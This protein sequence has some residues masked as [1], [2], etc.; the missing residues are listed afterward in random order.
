MP[1]PGNFHRLV[2]LGQVY[3]DTFA[4]SLSIVPVG[5]SL[6]V[7]TPEMAEDVGLIVLDWW[8]N[9]LGATGAGFLQNVRLTGVKLNLIGPDGRYA[10]DETGEYT[11]PAP[12]A[13]TM[14]A[15]APAQLS[16]VITLQSAIARGRGSKGR[17]YL[18]PSEPVVQVSSDGRVSAA[19]ALQQA[20]A[21]EYLINLLNAHYA[22][23]GMVGVASDQGAGVFAPVVEVRCGRVVDTVRSRRSSLDEDY[24]VHPVIA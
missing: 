17:M 12:V 18:P 4:T 23:T 9:A 24:Q 21:V 3:T 15:D 14:G 19:R 5:G 22:G 1:Y 11:L 8:N 7:V 6:G 16:M 10:Q 20:V 13:G 2:I